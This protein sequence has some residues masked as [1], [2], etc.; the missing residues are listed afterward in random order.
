[1]NSENKPASA[2]GDPETIGPGNGPPVERE[3]G[4]PMKVGGWC[5]TTI[6]G[7]IWIFG[8]GGGTLPLLLCA[9]VVAPLLSAAC[10]GAFSVIAKAGKGL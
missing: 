1:L 2:S 4:W 7:L 9:V 6:A 10:I 5:G 3:S 8:F